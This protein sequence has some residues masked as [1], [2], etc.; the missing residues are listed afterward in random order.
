MLAPRHLT[1]RYDGSRQSP[2]GRSPRDRLGSVKTRGIPRSRLSRRPPLNPS[3]GGSTS[4]TTSVSMYQGGLGRTEVCLARSVSRDSPARRPSYRYSLDYPSVP[5]VAS[6]SINSSEPHGRSRQRCPSPGTH[7]DYGGRSG[8]KPEFAPQVPGTPR[9]S[10]L[11][12][13]APANVRLPTLAAHYLSR[14]FHSLCALPS[15]PLSFRL[16]T[17]LPPELKDFGFPKVRRESVWTTP[18]TWS[19]AFIVKTTTVSDRLR[20]LN[21]RS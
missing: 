1:A 21:F 18:Y 5:R 4:R 20:A 19:V 17:I 2:A 10:R 3:S 7:P 6:P 8:Y 15:I 16:A 11:D 14:R 13:L 12:R 9:P